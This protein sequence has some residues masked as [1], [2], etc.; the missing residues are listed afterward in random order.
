LPI[1]IAV[2]GDVCLP[3]NRA[4]EEHQRKRCSRKLSHRRG[5]HGRL[6]GFGVRKNMQIW[7]VYSLHHPQFLKGHC[8]PKALL[9]VSSRTAD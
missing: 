5:V 7:D 1:E 2:L 4:L 6:V 8:R 3:K 9:L